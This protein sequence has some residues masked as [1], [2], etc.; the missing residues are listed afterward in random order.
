MEM[1]DGYV[2]EG[3]L[4]LYGSSVIRIRM[5]DRSATE[6]HA[7]DPHTPRSFSLLHVHVVQVGILFWCLCGFLKHSAWSRNADC[8]GVRQRRSPAV[9][10][11]V[12]P[13]G[14]LAARQVRAPARR[15]LRRDPGAC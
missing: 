7:L 3:S 6:M 2:C 15:A 14:R 5:Y 1:F 12:R 10:L 11:A 4:C 9:H 13:R 8:V